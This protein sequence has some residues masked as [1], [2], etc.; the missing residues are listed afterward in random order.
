MGWRC[1]GAASSVRTFTLLRLLKQI[2]SYLDSGTGYLVGPE[3]DVP[4]EQVGKEVPKLYVQ[5]I[6][7]PHS[8]RVEPRRGAWA[9]RA[10]TFT[11]NFLSC[12]VS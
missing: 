6:M 3:M 9:A 2:R 4:L 10:T 11:H 8:S 1:R 5:N 12:Q 7:W